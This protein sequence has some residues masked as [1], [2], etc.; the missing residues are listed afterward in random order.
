MIYIMAMMAFVIVWILII[1]G[2][3]YFS[4][5]GPG[6]TK[7]KLANLWIDRGQW[8]AVIREWYETPT[9]L[10]EQRKGL[11]EV[12]ISDDRVISLVRDSNGKWRHTDTGRIDYWYDSMLDAK[13]FLLERENGNS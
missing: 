8:T 6:E 2:V 11:P 10:W 5:R 7:W 3:I 12:R 4:P 13:I 9:T 1:V